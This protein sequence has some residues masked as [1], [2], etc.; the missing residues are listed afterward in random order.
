MFLENI[1]PEELKNLSYLCKNYQIEMEILIKAFRVG[2]TIDDLNVI[3]EKELNF[4]QL[5]EILDDINC[6]RRVLK[7]GNRYEDKEIQKIIKS[8]INK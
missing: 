2:M 7:K 6:Q 5:E 4:L 3:A 1:K 8:L